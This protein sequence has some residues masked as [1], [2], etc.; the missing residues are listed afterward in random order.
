MK[1]KTGEQVCA[2]Q[3][4]V[5]FLASETTVVGQCKDNALPHLDCSLLFIDVIL[6]HSTIDVSISIYYNCTAQLICINVSLKNTTMKMKCFYCLFCCLSKKCFFT[7][8][9]K[10]HYTQRWLFFLLLQILI[11]SKVS[12]HWSYLTKV[13]YFL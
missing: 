4:L 2:P 11:Y 6:K 9:N 7:I 5:L 1:K 13:V 8:N 10:L 3:S 12:Y